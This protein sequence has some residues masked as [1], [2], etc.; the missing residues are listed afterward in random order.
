MSEPPA[1]PES[2]SADDTAG[3]PSVCHRCGESA[4]CWVY[5][6]GRMVG[7]CSAHLPELFSDILDLRP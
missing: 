2:Y 4:G 6:H 5:G 3:Y 1:L 7:A